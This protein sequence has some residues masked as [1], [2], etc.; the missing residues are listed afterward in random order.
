MFSMEGE[1]KRTVLLSVRY[2]AAAIGRQALNFLLF[3]VWAHYLSPTDFGVLALLAISGTL[4]LR[5]VETPIGYALQRFYFRPDYVDRRDVL[6]FNLV[7][8]VAVSALAVIGVYC[9]AGPLV[10]RWLLRDPTLATTVRLHGL[11]VAFSITTSLSGVFVLLLE[12]ARIFNAASLLGV[13]ATGVVSIALLT[14]TNLGVSAVVLG[15]ASGLLLQTLI[16]LP[17]L[18]GHL[19]PTLSWAVLKEP[20]RFGYTALPS[21]Y[22]N[23]LIIA[24]DRYVLQFLQTTYVV[25]LYSFACNIGNLVTLAIGTPVIGGVWPTIRRM[26]AS[27]DRQRAFVRQMTT[28]VCAASVAMAVFLSVF[29]PEAIRILAWGKPEFAAA[30]VV[31]PLLAFSQALQ[32]LAA[33]TEAG[34]SLGNRP[35]YIS[36]IAIAC[37]AANIGLN[38]LLVPQFGLVGAGWATLTS[39]ILWNALHVYFSRRFYRLQ[40][41]VR[42]FLH[43]GL[44]G[45][46]VIVAARAF[47]EM[48]MLVAFPLKVLVVLGYPLLLLGTGFLT[49][50]EWQKLS[51]F[52]RGARRGGL[53]SMVGA[54]TQP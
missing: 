2:A 30:A 15:Q 25:G 46:L 33:F 52:A 23:I 42:R 31:V 5:S 35:A 53:K 3:A 49:A 13:V 51:S 32:G 36:G 37:A 7:L 50:D 39:F 1:S 54:L 6:L 19:R 38:L 47:P 14:A 16:C 4:V 26:E 11:W 40:F 10:A 18:R 17:T 28:F 8:F 22:S 24:G 45:A 20:L 44:A 34:I 9:V 27:P 29:S 21:G 48:G 12:R 41:D 43:A